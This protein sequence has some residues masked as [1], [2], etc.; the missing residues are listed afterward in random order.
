MIFIN[1]SEVVRK[2]IPWNAAHD[3]D[4]LSVNRWLFHA[5]LGSLNWWESVL[6][7]ECVGGRVC[8]WESVLVGECV[9][10]RVC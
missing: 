10:G 9:D 7:G 2:H 6:V 4:D 5:E 1:C 3:A 8:W